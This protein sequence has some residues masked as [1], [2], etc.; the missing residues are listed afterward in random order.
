MAGYIIAG[1]LLLALAHMASKASFW[2]GK[3]KEIYR[4]ALRDQRN[5]KAEI[6]NLQAGGAK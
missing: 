1:V 5:L 4:S 2:K 6:D 3:Y